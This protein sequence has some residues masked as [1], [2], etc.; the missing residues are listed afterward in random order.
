MPDVNARTVRRIASRAIANLHS[1]PSRSE[2]P[3]SAI[4]W[5]VDIPLSLFLTDP[6]RLGGC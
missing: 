5:D 6:S 2:R 4:Q 1:F 3:L